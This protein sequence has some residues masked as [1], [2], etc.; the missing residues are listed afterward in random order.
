MVDL[1]AGCKRCMGL[2]DVFACS[3]EC[4]PGLEPQNELQDAK[5]PMKLAGVARGSA[6]FLGLSA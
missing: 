5:Q 4:L 1:D 3:C 2:E 6:G